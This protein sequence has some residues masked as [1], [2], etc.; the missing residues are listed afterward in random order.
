[1]LLTNWT[2]SFLNWASPWL[3]RFYGLTAVI[4]V[5]SCNCASTSLIVGAL[6]KAWLILQE[7]VSQ[8]ISR[9]SYHQAPRQSLIHIA[10]TCPHSFD[11]WHAL[12][13][14]HEMNSIVH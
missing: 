5:R 6:L 14:Y 12:A 13:A 3:T 10:G 8:E 2:Q 7:A 11:Y 9:V 1:L 4:S